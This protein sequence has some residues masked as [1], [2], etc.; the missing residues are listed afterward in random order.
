LT[1]N[2]SLKF[3]ALKLSKTPMVDPQYELTLFRAFLS[4]QNSHLH[5]TGITEDHRNL[6]PWELEPVDCPTWSPSCLTLDWIHTIEIIDKWSEKSGNFF[7]SLS[8]IPFPTSGHCCILLFQ[9]SGGALSS[10]GSNLSVSLWL[11]HFL[12]LYTNNYRSPI[13]TIFLFF[14]HSTWYPWPC[15]IHDFP[16]VSYTLFDMEVIAFSH[17]L[18]V[19]W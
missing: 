15:F 12:L 4:S 17:T 3:L 8:H 18:T 16:L 14:P 13:L 2:I 10:P 6:H 19:V 7:T 11:A 5:H 9:S 1:P